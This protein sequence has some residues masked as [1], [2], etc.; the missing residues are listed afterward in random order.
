MSVCVAVGSS[1]VRWFV[2]WFVRL[3]FGQ[4]WLVEQSFE[5]EFE[6]DG[7]DCSTVRHAAFVAGGACVDL[8]S[9]VCHRRLPH[10]RMLERVKGRAL[11]GSELLSQLNSSVLEFPPVCYHGCRL[12]LVMGWWTRGSGERE[13]ERRSCGPLK[14]QR[15]GVWSQEKLQWRTKEGERVANL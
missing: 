10:G 9:R 14:K 4:L 6:G 7:G 12:R 5:F 11:H 8:L 13:R 2:R 15:I 1:L 3:D